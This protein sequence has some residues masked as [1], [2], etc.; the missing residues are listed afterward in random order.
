MTG[1]ASR[2]P[3]MGVA[4]ALTA[5]AFT[6]SACASGPSEEEFLKEANAVC[7][8]HRATIEEAASKVLAG[9]ALP[10]PEEFGALA[11]ETIIPELT[12]QFRELGDIEAPEDLAVSFDD[13]LSQADEAVTALADDPSMLTNADNFTAPNQQSDEVGLSDACHIGP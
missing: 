1:R 7:T 11:Q 8:E 6:A 9:G 4:V 2:S 5:V 13:F 10:K 3:R 12:A